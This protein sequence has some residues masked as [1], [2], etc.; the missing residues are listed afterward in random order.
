MIL[1]YFHLED[2]FN[3][4]RGVFKNT[5]TDAAIPSVFYLTA[6]NLHIMMPKEFCSQSVT[7]LTSSLCMINLWLLW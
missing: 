2:H 6:R 4:I 3:N 7:L 1:V 5:R